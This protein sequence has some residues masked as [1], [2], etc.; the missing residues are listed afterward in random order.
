MEYKYGDIEKVLHTSFV[1]EA[2]ALKTGLSYK[3]VHEHIAELTADAFI[4]RAVQL[5]GPETKNIVAA[6]AEELVK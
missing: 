2:I 3:E 5:A 1:A 6:I 4:G